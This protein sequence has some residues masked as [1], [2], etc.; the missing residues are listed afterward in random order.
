MY[1]NADC[2]IQAILPTEHK[3]AFINLF[4]SKDIYE[5]A[6]TSEY[7]G[8]VFKNGYA[9]EFNEED[10]QHGLSAVKITFLAEQSIYDFMLSQDNDLILQDVCKE[11]K[12][13][14]LIAYGKNENEGTEET[15][16]FDHKCKFVYASRDLFPEPF[17]D[18]YLSPNE[19]LNDSEEC[20]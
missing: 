5:H 4:L 10:N 14:R 18:C 15:V 20:M 16:Q 17:L 6:N 3:R 12:I 7:N 11:L 19:R 2:T 8:R 1:L 9:Y 13:K